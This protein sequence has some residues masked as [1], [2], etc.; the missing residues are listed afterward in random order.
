MLPFSLRSYRRLAAEA[1]SR[2]AESEAPGNVSKLQQ[3][4]SLS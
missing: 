3:K 1:E 4:S 2:R